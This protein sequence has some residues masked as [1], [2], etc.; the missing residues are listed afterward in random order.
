MAK[1]KSP[2]IPKEIDFT[3]E[4]RN[5]IYEKLIEYAVS[6]CDKFSLVWREDLG[7]KK[8]ENEI[9]KKLEPYAISN[10]ITTKWPGTEI[11]SGTANLST[12]K[13]N[14]E[15]AKILKI[16]KSLYQ[17]EAPD[18]PED[19]ALYLKNGELWL[20]SVAHEQMG[21]LCTENIP[22]PQLKDILSFLYG[23]GIINKQYI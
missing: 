3:D 11:F 2:N 21:W 23:N 10:I 17:W 12:Y 5:N 16:A 9:A 7:H 20:G 6:Q 18:F 19:L 4:P 22:E 14:P 1:R 13:L 15:T 8:E